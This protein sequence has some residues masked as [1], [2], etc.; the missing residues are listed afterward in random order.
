MDEGVGM[1]VYPWRTS[2]FSISLCPAPV[3]GSNPDGDIENESVRKDFRK[4][5]QGFDTADKDS[6]VPNPVCIF[7]IEKMQEP[8]K[9]E[10]CHA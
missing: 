2:V 6:V 1:F 10:T 5:Q 4:K 9:I 8:K 3:C 7:I